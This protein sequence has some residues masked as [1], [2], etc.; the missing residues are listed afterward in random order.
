MFYKGFK[1]SEK[2]KQE[3]SDRMKGNKNLLGHKH[4][5]ETR[6]KMSLSHRGKHPGLGFKK[7]H[8]PWNSGIKM[9]NEIREKISRSNKGRILSNEHKSKISISHKGKICSE[10]CK[11]IIS[12]KNRGRISWNKGISLLSYCSLN[13]KERI[14]EGFRKMMCK[15]NF[16]EIKLT[17]ILENLYSNKWKYVGNGIVWIGDKNPDFINVNGQK[18]LIELFGEQWH[19]PEDEKIR[20]DYFRLFGFDTLIIWAKELRFQDKLEAKLN[21]FVGERICQNQ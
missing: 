10:K 2:T 17:K 16:S 21:N 13:S 18:K 7:G 19:K 4:S 3:M 5:N 20:S 8:I 6:I 1:H 9:S 15:P 11:E 14:K 12:E